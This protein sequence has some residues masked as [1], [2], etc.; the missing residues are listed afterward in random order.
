MSSGTYLSASKLVLLVAVEQYSRH[1]DWG[2]E[3]LCEIAGFLVECTYE[4]A[5]TFDMAALRDQLAAVVIHSESQS[6]HELLVRRIGELRSL[7]AFFNFFDGLK[8]LVVDAESRVEADEDAVLL[9]SESILGVFV[10]R[11]CLAFDQ[12]EFH[13][14]GTLHTECARALGSPIFSPATTGASSAAT[15]ARSQC[16]LQE[17]VEFQIGLLEAGAG[18]PVPEVM[19]RQVKQVMQ[20]IPEYARAHYLN[21]LNHARVGEYQQSEASLRR[22]FDSTTVKDN[23]TVYQYALLYLAAVRARLGMVDEA[24]CALTEAT[25]IARDCQD[26]TCLLYI[27]SWETGLVLSRQECTRLPETEVYRAL[28]ALIDKAR[29]MHNYELQA[30]GHLRLTELL[31]STGAAP[32]KVFESLVYSSALIA[33]N[34]V[35]SLSRSWS[36]TAARAWAAYGSEW[37]SLLH[38]VLAQ[39]ERPGAVGITENESVELLRQLARITS[40]L[41][42]PAAAIRMLEAN[43]SSAVLVS[44]GSADELERMLEWL[45]LESCSE[46]SDAAP[47]LPPST[48]DDAG[49]GRLREIRDLITRG[50]NSDAMVL[51]ARLCSE[52]EAGRQR[53]SAVQSIARQLLASA[54]QPL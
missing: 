50:Y 22:F 54:E 2:P 47:A 8:Q 23:R 48:H 36:L 13:Q 12:L 38:I 27:M 43:M 40:S 33:E 5:W 10:R 30:I 26:H 39:H 19:E 3:A 46:D 17:Y 29:R 20:L 25:H 34:D 44:P 24:R 6:L 4:P 16:E 28:A 37:V 52:E 45:R 21:Y 32:Q 11:C 31:V 35:S 15:A 7:D 49:T 18:A 14:A 1:Y 42:G 9:D 53:S 41:C 51:L